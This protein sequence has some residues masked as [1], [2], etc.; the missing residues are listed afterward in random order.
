M[1]PIKINADYEISLFEN[2]SPPKIINQSLEYLAFFLD[3]RPIVTE[4]K[5]SQEYLDYVTKLTG[6]QPSFSISQDYENWWGSLKN[7]SLEKKLNSKEYSAAF[8]SDSQII[9]QIEDIKIEQ[10]KTYLAKNP[11][12]MSGQNFFKFSTT[13]ELRSSVLLNK[14]NKI[15]VEPFFDRKKDFSHYIFSD[16][17]FICYENLVDEKFQYKGTVFRNIHELSYE[18]LSFYS[19]I[20]PNEWKRFEKEFGL[21]REKIRAEG[22]SEGYSMDSFTYLEEGKLKIRTCSEINYRKTMGLLT[23]LFSKKFAAKNSCT[24]LVLG[25]FTKNPQLFESILERIK[26]L[27]GCMYLS[28]GDTRFETFLLGASSFEELRQTFRNLKMLLPDGQFPVEI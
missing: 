22:G 27:D 20:D 6:H 3:D 23:W 4:K 26:S 25:S 1:K 12:G 24:M 8:S 18:S 28:P 9:S 17:T 14:S 15:L 2:K 11:F 19:E 13:Q 10:G 5:Y 7:I 16:G 21:I